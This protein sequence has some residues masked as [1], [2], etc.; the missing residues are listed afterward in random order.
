MAWKIHGKTKLWSLASLGLAVGFGLLYNP[1]SATS[2]SLLPL[3]F[4]LIAG[5]TVFI[6]AYA[7]YFLRGRLSNTSLGILQAV[8]GGVLAYLA[9]ETG[10][11]AAEYVEEL[12]RWETI[13][14]FVVA[15][16]VTTLAFV[17]TFLVLTRVEK[18]AIRSGFEQSTATAF[19][20]AAALGVHNVGEGFAIAASLLAGALA[21]AVLFTV[22][23][24]VHNATEGFAIVGPLL[25]GRKNPPLLSLFWLSLLAGLPTVAGAGVYY[26]GVTHGLVLAVLNSVANA[27]IVYAMLHVNLN[28]LSKLGG[29]MSPK[30]WL[31]L[32]LG[33][34]L[35]F[36]TESVVMLS[37]FEA[38]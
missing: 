16:I 32:T 21:S 23:F 38:Q 12:A 25:A 35:A 37:G 8:A 13:G 5:I 27:S 2:V 1:P 22:G 11:A 31:S 34:A 6:G 17:L 33:V 18:A 10:H 20:V 15:S 14:D 24:A 29:V 28:A 19:I 3:V 26:L 7:L 9:L 4:G 30:F 36:T